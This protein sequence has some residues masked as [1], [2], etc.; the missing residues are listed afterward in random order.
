MSKLYLQPLY[1]L[2]RVLVRWRLLISKCQNKK[3]NLLLFEDLQRVRTKRNGANKAC[4][5]LVL[6]T[7]VVPALFVGIVNINNTNIVLHN[8]RIHACIFMYT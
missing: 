4:L 5:L 2:G 3:K 7:A 8:M 1:E 6:L